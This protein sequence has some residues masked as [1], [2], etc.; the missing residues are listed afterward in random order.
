MDHKDVKEATDETTVPVVFEGTK[1]VL[2]QSMDVDDALRILIKK[3]HPLMWR[4]HCW[5]LRKK[6]KIQKPARPNQFC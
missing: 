3:R 4:F 5:R 2:P 1:I 6:R